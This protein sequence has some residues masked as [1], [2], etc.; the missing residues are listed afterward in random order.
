MT[1]RR[2]GNLESALCPLRRSESRAPAEVIV[3]S[4]ASSTGEI[5]AGLLKKL[6]PRGRM[7]APVTCP[8]GSQAMV[9]QW[10][11]WRAVRKPG[12]RSRQ[13]CTGLP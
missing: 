1:F 4:A 3:V 2:G 6:R 13:R 12:H 10:G 7:I 8:D 9:T 5:P 11:P